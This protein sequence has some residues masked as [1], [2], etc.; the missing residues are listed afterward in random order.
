MTG[1]R[2]LGNRIEEEIAG[3]LSDKGFWVHLLN[4]NRAGQP[5]DIIAVKYGIAVLIDAKNCSTDRF[6]THRIESNQLGSMTLWKSCRN[7]EWWFACKMKDGEIYM[8]NGYAAVSH[9]TS[10]S[11]KDMDLP[12]ERW[13]REFENKY[14]K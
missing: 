12:I 6:D 11:R 7:K 4:Q 10:I 8:V 13:C 14:W 2:T 1:N 9:D 3:Y 5:A